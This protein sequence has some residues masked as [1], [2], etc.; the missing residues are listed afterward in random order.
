MS[1]A[2]SDFDGL[3]DWGRLQ[4]W[5]A[6]QAAL[7]G[8]GPVTAAEQLTGGSQNNIFL[9]T[10]GGRAHGA[11]TPAP[12]PAQ[13]QQRHD[14]ARSARAQRDRRAAVCRTPNSSRCAPTPT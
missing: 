4:E 1:E 10:R 5:V 14:A 12:A 9:L 11:A 3:L 6:A 13:E 7:P 2:L 8:E